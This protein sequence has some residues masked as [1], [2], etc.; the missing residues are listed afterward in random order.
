MASAML[1][2]KH[3]LGLD[4]MAFLMAVARE[5]V[6]VS[7]VANST[8]QQYLRMLRGMATVP[9]RLLRKLFGFGLRFSLASRPRRIILGLCF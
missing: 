4:S 2:K 1:L 8:A 7:C 6:R 5:S 9:P 3:L